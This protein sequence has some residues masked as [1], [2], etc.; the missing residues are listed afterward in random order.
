MT[1]ALI[2]DGCGRLASSADPLDDDPTRRWWALCPG[3][4]PG[5]GLLAIHHSFDETVEALR[6]LADEPA[7]E[8]DFEDEPERHFC[9][10]SCLF[11]WLG[12]RIA[13]EGNGPPTSS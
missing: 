10:T 4:T 11:D 6:D 5:G 8:P 13:A 1:S 9:A 2:C 7:D 12:A 3:P